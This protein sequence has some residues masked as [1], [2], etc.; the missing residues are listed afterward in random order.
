[1]RLYYK[2]N[3]LQL[4]ETS[5]HVSAKGKTDFNLK[6]PAGSFTTPAKK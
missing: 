2:D 4:P 5:V 3:W 6:V 1:M